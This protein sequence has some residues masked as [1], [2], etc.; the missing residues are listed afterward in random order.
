[1]FNVPVPLVTIT[2]YS[3]LF[4]ITLN[5]SFNPSPLRPNKVT[6]IVTFSSDKNLPLVLTVNSVTFKFETFK[7]Y[8]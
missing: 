1:M 2:A 3:A 5:V 8:V 6:F 4:T 7:C